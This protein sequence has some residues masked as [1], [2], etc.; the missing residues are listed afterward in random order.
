MLPVDADDDD[1][2]AVEDEEKEGED[3]ETDA[4][5]DVG[6]SDAENSPLADMLVTLYK[7]PPWKA[8][9]ASV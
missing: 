9:M 4:E 6:E 3:D 8:A 5:D 1:A 7:S 2:D